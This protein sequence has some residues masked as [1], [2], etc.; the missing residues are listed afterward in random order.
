MSEF[1]E[2]SQDELNELE[3]SVDIEDFVG[4]LLSFP[5]FTEANLE[6]DANDIFQLV[7]DS[8]RQDQLTEE[9]DLVVELLFHLNES[10]SPF[11]LKRALE[12]WTEE[13]LASFG[14]LIWEE[15]EI[16]EDDSNNN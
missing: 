4:K 11:N 6:K 7:V 9:Q 8:Y 2:D 10:S 3:V 16:E 12:V 1:N 5:C 14:D 15:E 13:D